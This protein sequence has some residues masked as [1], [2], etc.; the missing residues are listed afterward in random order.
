VCAP[1]CPVALIPIEGDHSQGKKMLSCSLL[2]PAAIINGAGPLQTFKS[3]WERDK[4]TALL[5]KFF[6]TPHPPI[7]LG[8]VFTPGKLGFMPL[9]IYASFA[10]NSTSYWAPTVPRNIVVARH[11]PSYQS[12]RH[13][14]VVSSPR[15]HT[16]RDRATGFCFNGIFMARYFEW[17]SNEQESLNHA[18]T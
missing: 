17:S 6:L 4:P 8:V 12:V 13:S 9:C 14:G 2:Q 18:K 7:Q 3:L 10:L 1:C 16:L 11:C 5:L 15:T